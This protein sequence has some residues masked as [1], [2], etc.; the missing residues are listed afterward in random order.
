MYLFQV[1]SN[2]TATGILPVNV[3][4]LYFIIILHVFLNKK[5]VY[6][7]IYILG[8]RKQKQKKNKNKKGVRIDTPAAAA[9]AQ[10][11]VE[12]QSK[13]YYLHV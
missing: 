6:N 12:D 13:G 3:R 5:Y 4:I 7:V 1:V 9:T 2:A 8:N 11:K 10:H